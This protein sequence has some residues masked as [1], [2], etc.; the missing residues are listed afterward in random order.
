MN[1]QTN[2]NKLLIAFRRFNE[3]SSHE[4]T[5][6][7]ERKSL[8]RTQS[9]GQLFESYSHDEIRMSMTPKHTALERGKFSRSNSRIWIASAYLLI[10]GQAHNKSSLEKTSGKMP[11]SMRT[12]AIFDSAVHR[13]S[14]LSFRDTSSGLH[15]NG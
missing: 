13:C 8:E 15:S 4:V 12:P 5:V 3:V 11:F 9:G 7:K 14:E 1:H 10:I 6:T 2:L